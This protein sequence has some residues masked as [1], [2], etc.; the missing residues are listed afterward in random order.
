MPDTA[1]WVEKGR[2]DVPFAGEYIP[3]GH[4]VCTLLVEGKTRQACWQHLLTG[5]RAVRQEIGEKTI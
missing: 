5:V 3:A 1:E 4:P 2:R